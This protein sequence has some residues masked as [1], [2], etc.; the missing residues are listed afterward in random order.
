MFILKLKNLAK[1]QTQDTPKHTNHSFCLPSVWIC[2]PTPSAQPIQ[3]VPSVNARYFNSQPERAPPLA[4]PTHCSRRAQTLRTLAAAQLWEQQERITGQRSSPIRT[5]DLWLHTPEACQTLT[6]SMLTHFP[7][8]L[9]TDLQNPFPIPILDLKF[10][11]KQNTGLNLFLK[12]RIWIVA[13]INLW[14]V[15][16]EGR[17]VAEF[18]RLDLDL[19]GTENEQRPWLCSLGERLWLCT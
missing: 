7:S 17:R 1:E 12:N 8:L 3:L 11:G 13:N 16:G 6:V 10:N 19:R 4:V 9:Q 15:V 2:L 5:D 18:C 14:V